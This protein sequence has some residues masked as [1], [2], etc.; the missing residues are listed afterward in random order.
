M[1]AGTGQATAVD[2]LLRHFTTGTLPLFAARGWDSG[3]GGLVERLAADGTPMPTAFRRARVHGR[4]LY[5]FSFWARALGD[6][7]YAALADRIFEYLVERF[8]DRDAG[9]WIEAVDPNGNP[10]DRDKDLYT[11]AFVLFGLASY[12]SCLDRTDARPHLDDTLGY[13][14]ER[15]RRSPGLYHERLDR[16]GSPASDKLDQNPLMHLV[17][18]LLHVDQCC[19]RPDLVPE[20]GAIIATAERHFRRNGAIVEHLTAGLEPHPAM[21]RFVEPGHQMEWAWLMDWHRRSVGADGPAEAAADLVANGLR[22]GWDRRYGGLFDRIDGVDGTILLDTKRLWPIL[23][24]IKA[25]AVYPGRVA[26]A[27]LGVEEATR[28]LLHHYLRPGGGWTER[29]NA[30]LTPADTTM[31][32]SSCYHISMAVAETARL[33][34]LDLARH[35]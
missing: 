25:L 22:A 35:R 14:F 34:G 11:H 16:S 10:L 20:A 30:D 33:A 31:P 7:A 12:L 13:V 32:S 5:V 9:G 4:Q 2:D 15:F 1:G 18:A 27:S 21:G 17:E 3:R 6:S 8:R 26:D 24:L 28:F 19:G 23:E 29:L